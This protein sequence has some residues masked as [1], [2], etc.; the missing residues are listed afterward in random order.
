MVRCA[1]CGRVY[2]PY[3]QKN[4]QYF[5][6]RCAVGCANSKKSFNVTFL[7]QEVGKFIAALSFTENELTQLDA[8]TSTYIALFEEKRLKEIEANDRRKKKVREDLSYL[9]IN[10]LQLLKS[11]VY[12][13]ES[14]LQEETRLNRELLVTQDNEMTSDQSMQAVMDDIQKLSELLKHGSA[15]YSPAKSNEKEQIIKIIF[16]ELLVSGT[17]LQ[18]KCKNGFRA[19][20]DAFYLFVTHNLAFRTFSTWAIRRDQPP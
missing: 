14:L 3:L 10:K 13:P 17:T 4:I 8:S 19:W 15:H 5:G 11:G 20:K 12:T 6:A 9:R 18:Y 1:D 7:E 2:T 16:S